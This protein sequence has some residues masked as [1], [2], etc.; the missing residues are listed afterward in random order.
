[1]KIKERPAKKPYRGRNT[2][3]WKDVTA[4]E[5]G[6]MAQIE[7]EKE[8]RRGE[9]RYRLGFV[10]FV[11]GIPLVVGAIILVAVLA[12]NGYLR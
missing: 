1:M 11:F 9:A 6:E 3:R 2:K 12:A 5:L 7:E 10:A 8:A 4:E